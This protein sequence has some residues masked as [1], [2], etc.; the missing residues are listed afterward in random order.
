MSFYFI[1]NS[2]VGQHEF[3][4]LSNDSGRRLEQTITPKMR[5]TEKADE[6]KKSWIIEIMS[7]KVISLSPKDTVKK[8]IEIFKKENIHHIPVL[9]NKKI[10]G[11]ISDRDVM[12]LNIMELDNVTDLKDYM[13][14]IVV[15][16][17]EDTPIDYLAQVFYQEKISGMPVLDSNMDLV[18]I[19]THN[20]IL[21]WIFERR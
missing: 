15:A 4:Y 18:G 9:K 20:D 13:K 11:M 21:R 5:K 6:S 10:V 3:D 17:D 12:W 2:K 19:V 7:K 8:A 16:C 1:I 14:K